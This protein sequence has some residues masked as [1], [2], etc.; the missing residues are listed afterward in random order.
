M[1]KKRSVWNVGAADVRVW[2]LALGMLALAVAGAQADTIDLGRGPVQVVVP[3][4]YDPA[5]P[6]IPLIVTLHGLGSSGAGGESAH[7]FTPHAHAYGFLY[8][9]PDGT[10]QLG[11][12]SLFWNSRHACYLYRYYDYGGV[13]DSGYLRRLID[14][15]KARYNV[16]PRR[17]LV[18]G[19]SNGGFMAYRL[20]YEHADAIAAIASFGSGMCISL[21]G[22][23]PAAPLHVLEI[24]GTSDATVSYYGTCCNSG[25]RPGAVETV[26]MWATYNGCALQPDTSAPPLDLYPDLAGNETSISRYTAGCEPGGSA[27]LWT[28][29]N[30][31]HVPPFPV[32]RWHL[33]VEWLLA[34]SKPDDCNGNSIP[35]AQDIANGTS[36]DCN[37]NLF[38]DECEP[39][40]NGNGVVDSCDIRA[41][42]A[43][44]CNGDLIP[45]ECERILFVDANA[46]GCRSGLSWANAFINLQDA[47]TLAARSRCVVQEIWVAAGTYRPLIQSTATVMRTETFQLVSGV[48]IYGGFAGS[49][50]D[51]AQRDPT[52]NPTVLTGEFYYG[53]TRYNTY[54][55]VTTSGVD[56]TAVLD[57]FVITAGNAN[58]SSGVYGTGGGV[59]NADGSPTI[60]NCVFRG[61]GARTGAGLY[62][63]AGTPTLINCTF[64]GNAA[65]TSGGAL[66]HASGNLTLVNCT[67]AGNAATTSGGGVYTTGSGLTLANGILWGNT[68]GGATVES[69]QIIG[70]TPAVRFSCIQGLG[71]LAGNGNIGDDPLFVRNPSDGGDGWGD[72]PATPAVN[73]GANDD[74]GDLPLRVGSPCIDGGNNAALPSGTLTDPDSHLR[75]FDDPATSDCRW[76]PGTCGAPPIVDMGAYEFIPVIPGDFDRDGD[77]DRDDFITF[78]TCAGGPAL[79]YAPGCALMLDT[80]GFILADSDRD[81]DV[82]QDDFG[83]FQR[84]YSGT[85][86]PADPTCIE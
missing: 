29:L 13:D 78:E 68:G 33:V 30:G 34:H 75:F 40:C 8:A 80:Q 22:C 84:C 36:R 14:A 83:V 57:G 54:Q 28:V 10:R 79:P 24:H 76:V 71:A 86:K 26:E 43:Q 67:L 37:G 17:V 1:F 20:A 41:G 18:F 2:G 64:S 81:A 52:A 70:G 12:S 48:A 11:T 55:V 35:D 25:C 9:Y 73:E 49:E 69:K 7:Q 51:R 16:D 39:D 46:H 19:Y 58:G 77:V 21:A 47:L 65:T 31:Y 45:D 63:G 60:V 23:S 4:G 6:P 38:P 61:N 5:G 85:G 53:G 44:D 59:Y 74:Y 32:D 62:S 50:T 15:L 42:T 72:N 82:D 3:S 66:Y 27:E 56:A